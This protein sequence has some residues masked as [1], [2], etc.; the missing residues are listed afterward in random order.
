MK[1]I[2]IIGHG[3]VGKA[4]EEFFVRR[5]DLYNIAITDPKYNGSEYF[6]E[7]KGVSIKNIDSVA[8]WAD[9]I[10]LSVP[11]PIGDDGSCDTFLVEETLA[12]I[13]REIRNQ[14]AQN[15]ERI[16]IIK[17]TVAVGTSQMLD[18]KYSTFRVV[19]SPEFCGESKYWSSYDFDTE[20][21]AT[22]FF[23][24]GGYPQIT[25][26]CVDL[27]LTVAGPQKQYFQCGYKEA[28]LTKYIENSFYATKIA[29]CNQMYDLC[30]SMGIDWNTVR[31]AWQLDPRVSPMHT[32]VFADDRGFGG[33]CFPKDALA[34]LMTSRKAG[35]EATI[36]DEVLKY[37]DE[38]RTAQDER[39]KGISNS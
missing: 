32:A 15:K 13:D 29:F 4:M 5:K 8:I 9:Y 18:N 12:T 7:D 33:K 27:F 28:E 20:V 17:S 35:A 38:L 10:I 23:I 30:Q 11:T 34:L 26:K 3:Y 6:I 21:A 19:F 36:L 2:A 14:K 37:N 24:F 1:N 22:P 16:V 39:R 25:S 31:E